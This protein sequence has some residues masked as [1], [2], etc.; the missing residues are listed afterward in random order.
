MGNNS[1]KGLRIYLGVV[2]LGVCFLA[3]SQAIGWKWIG[4]SGTTPPEGEKK[5]GFRYFYHK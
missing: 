2:I 3:Y 1:L 5:N 4:A